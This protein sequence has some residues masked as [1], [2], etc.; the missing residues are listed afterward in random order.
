MALSA[1]LGQGKLNRE[2]RAP[3]KDGISVLSNKVDNIVNFPTT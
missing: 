1:G 2:R 3:G